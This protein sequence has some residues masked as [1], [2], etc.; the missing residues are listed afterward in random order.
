LQKI[1]RMKFWTDAKKVMLP[2]VHFM[3]SVDAA[4]NQDGVEDPRGV[5]GQDLIIIDGRKSRQSPGTRKRK[6][7]RVEIG[8]ELRIRKKRC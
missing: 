7:R 4:G 3:T 1:D 6:V 2:T 8:G 5:E